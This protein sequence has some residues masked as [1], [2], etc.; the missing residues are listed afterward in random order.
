MS[1]VSEIYDD[2]NYNSFLANRSEWYKKYPDQFIIIS[3]GWVQGGAE[4]PAQAIKLARA[5]DQIEGEVLILRCTLKE[6]SY[7]LFSFDKAP[8]DGKEASKPSIT[9]RYMEAAAKVSPLISDSK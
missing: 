9:G 8:S 3:D 2:Y 4:T 6:P 7:Y 1:I 5:S